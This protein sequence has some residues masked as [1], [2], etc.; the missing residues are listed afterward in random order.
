MGKIKVNKYGIFSSPHSPNTLNKEIK[1]K[2]TQYV[3]LLKCNIRIPI[4]LKLQ[5]KKKK[6]SQYSKSELYQYLLKYHYTKRALKKS[7][8]YSNIAF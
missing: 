6:G 1:E 7:K 3:I 2:I 4:A 5:K 8:K